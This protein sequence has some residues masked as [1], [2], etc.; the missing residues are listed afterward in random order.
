MP[1]IVDHAE[2]RRIVAEVAA[3]LV[4]EG[5]IDAV[6]V[7]DIAARA[8]TSTAI[9]SHYFRGKRELLLVTFDQAAG[10]ARRRF[11]AALAA[12]PADL[13]GCCEA[14]LP[15][16]D[17]RRRDW[18]VWFSFWGRA[19]ADPELGAN[20]RRRVRETR[21]RIAEVVLAARP[22][23]DVDGA[24]AHAR[25]ILTAITGIATQAV[26]DPQDWPAER[27]REVL[28][29][30]LDDACAADPDAR[31]RRVEGVPASPGSVTTTPSGSPSTRGG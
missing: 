12:D 7:R 30:D 27:Q 31:A 3:D 4:A 18:Q 6:T 22:D 23:L 5:G 20:Q 16:D 15:L 11:A 21:A 1:R 14:L 17:E 9:V 24:T 10:R 8:G 25:R 2:R 29:V 13:R 19:V 28:A 26:F